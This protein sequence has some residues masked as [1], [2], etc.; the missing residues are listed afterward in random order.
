MF[1]LLLNVL[2]KMAPRLEEQSSLYAPAVEEHGRSP[3]I[4]FHGDYVIKTFAPDNVFV[5]LGF[6]GPNTSGAIG[7]KNPLPSENFRLD[8]KFS[9]TPG[10]LP[11]EGVDFVLSKTEFDPA[12]AYGKSVQ[13]DNIVLQLST[14]EKNPTLKIF[15]RG[16]ENSV[17]LKRHIYNAVCTLRL[18]NVENTLKVTIS[19]NDQEFK[20]VLTLPNSGIEK[21][22]YYSVVTGNTRGYNI[23]RLFGVRANTMDYISGD[24]YTERKSNK[25]VW[26]VFIS[27]SVAIGYLL[28]KR[29][30]KSQTMKN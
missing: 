27:A 29:Q 8:F 12:T 13:N 23:M 24:E 22:M 19:L 4:S 21:N 18:E 3:R 14:K 25:V 20:Q 26:L 11:G 1:T 16:F 5:Q 28:F 7:L 6:K 10:D 15:A 30:A 17:E 2:C 9:L